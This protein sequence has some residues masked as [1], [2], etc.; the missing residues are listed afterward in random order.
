MHKNTLQPSDFLEILI[1]V[2]KELTTTEIFV[3]VTADQTQ[4]PH[5]AAFW[6]KNR[7]LHIKTNW[8]KKPQ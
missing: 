1:R 6:E 4:I 8:G 7:K 3:T 5:E 2:L